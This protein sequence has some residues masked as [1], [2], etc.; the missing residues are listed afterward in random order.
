MNILSRKISLEHLQADMLAVNDTE[1]VTLEIDG[2][3][4]IAKVEYKEGNTIAKLKAGL[5]IGGEDNSEFRVEIVY[6]IIVEIEG[7]V[8]EEEIEENFEDLSKGIGRKI[9]Y[10]NSFITNELINTPLVLPPSI[11]KGHNKDK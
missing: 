10:I 5:S 1:S 3:Q 9:S 8:T 7:E 4:S 11:I 6:K 2:K